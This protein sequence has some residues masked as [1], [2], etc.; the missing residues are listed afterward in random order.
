[1]TI[2]F[3][4]DGGSASGG[5]LDGRLAS[6]FEARDLTQAFLVR[7]GPTLIDPDR[8]GSRREAVAK[9]RH[10][11]RAK[12]NLFDS[13][14]GGLSEAEGERSALLAQLRSEDFADSRDTLNHQLEVCVERIETV[15]ENVPDVIE[16]FLPEAPD[17]D[18]ALVAGYHDF[19]DHLRKLRDRILDG[20]D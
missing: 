7:H 5:P 10:D 8:I 1:V 16:E 4:H 14:A 20:D 3:D 18:P 19:L 9:F 17:I 2:A 15:C 6:A 12:L 11:L 13:I